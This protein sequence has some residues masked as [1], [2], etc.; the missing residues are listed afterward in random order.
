MHCF[1]QTDEPERRSTLP[2]DLFFVRRALIPRRTNEE[3]IVLS[4]SCAAQQGQQT[5]TNCILIPRR[6]R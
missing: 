2:P 3:I 5:R 6:L 4:M 1:A